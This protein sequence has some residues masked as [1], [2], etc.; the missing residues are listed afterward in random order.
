MYF[1]MIICVSHNIWQTVYQSLFTLFS[2]GNWNSLVARKG[3]YFIFI[4][5]GIFGIFEKKKIKM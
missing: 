2:W 1:I 5:K 3:Y 4:S